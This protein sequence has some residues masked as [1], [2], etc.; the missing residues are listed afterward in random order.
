MAQLTAL[1][2]WYTY[3]SPH[4]TVGIRND[5]QLW[6]ILDSWRT[7]LLN[8][9]WSFVR[10]SAPDENDRCMTQTTPVLALRVGYFESSDVVSHKV[11]FNLLCVARVWS[12][13]LCKSVFSREYATQFIQRIFVVETYMTI[14]TKSYE[15]CCRRR[16]LSVSVYSKSSMSER[17]RSYSNT[18]SN[19][20]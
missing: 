3:A 17:W 19:M 5:L 20:Q 18:Y 4:V 13:V 10:N 7:G 2:S 15:K 11:Q 12:T 14:R 9:A 16:F 1:L 8:T 6:D